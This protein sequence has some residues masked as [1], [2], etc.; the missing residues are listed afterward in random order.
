MDAHCE[1]LDRRSS[2]VQA[3]HDVTFYEAVAANIAATVGLCLILT[4][5]VFGLNVV[6]APPGTIHPIALIAG[7]VLVG[8]TFLSGVRGALNGGIVLTRTGI[9]GV[10][11]PASKEMRWNAITSVHATSAG[12]LIE[13]NHA[14]CM[15][16]S[17]RAANPVATGLVIAH[18]HPDLMQSSASPMAE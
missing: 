16:L 13:L 18:F 9:R 7:I 5:F 6:L 11:D 17:G 15:T 10:R 1:V 8:A 4:L 14:R 2:A 3:G 12:L